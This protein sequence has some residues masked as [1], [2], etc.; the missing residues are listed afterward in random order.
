MPKEDAEDRLQAFYGLAVLLVYG[1]D[2]TGRRAAD[3]VHLQKRFCLLQL[4]KGHLDIL[5]PGLLLLNVALPGELGAAQLLGRDE[6]R[7]PEGPVVAGLG[8]VLG[9]GGRP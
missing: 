5:L 3:F 4:A 6:A 7:R 8:F 2:D 9:L 1:L